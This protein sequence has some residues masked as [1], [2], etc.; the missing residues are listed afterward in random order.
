MFKRILVPVDGSSTAD[1][2]LETA[3]GLAR[4][5]R[6]VLDDKEIRLREPVLAPDALIIPDRT[7]P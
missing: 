3:I 2:G 6:A 7:R 4:D 5:Q 1:Q